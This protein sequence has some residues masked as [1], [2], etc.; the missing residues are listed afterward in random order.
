MTSHRTDPGPGHSSGSIR[1]IALVGHSGSGKTTLVEQLL[2][3][4]GTIGKPGRVEDGS[5]VCDFEAEEKSHG[6]SLYPA[7]ATVRHGGLVVHLIDTPGFPDFLGQTL[8]VLPASETVAVVV[9]ADKGI[10]TTTRRI[11]AVA[12]QRRLPRMVVVNRI[13]DHLGECEELLDRLRETF[14]SELLPIN[15]PTPDGSG[16]ADL[17]SSERG[18]SAF[19]SVAEAHQRL[20]DQVVEVD[21]ELMS[22]YLES[23]SVSPESLRAAFQKALR[24]GHL[25][26]VCFCSAKTGAGVEALLEIFEQLCPSPLEGNPRPFV[27]TTPEGESPYEPRPDPAGK[28]VGHVFKVTTDPFV[29][30]LCL[31]RIHQGTLKAGDSV[32]VNDG[33]KPVRIAHIHEVHG[34]EHPEIARAV[35]GDIVCITKVEDLH[36][37]DVIHGGTDLGGLRFRA[38]EMPR[39][40]YGLALA[41]KS[42]SDEA[43][44]ST[45]LAKL[46][47]EDPTFEVERVAATHQL[48]AR[49]MGELHMRVALERLRNRFKLDLD[50]E[51]PKVAYKE[52]VSS[53]AEGHHRHKKQTGGAG[54]FGEVSL[55]VEPIL[56]DD[57]LP[58]HR[59]FEFVDATVG[60]AVPRQFMPAIEKGIRQ[61]LAEGAIAGY[62][63]GG[64]RVEVFDGKHHPV[65]S[66]EVAFVTAGRRAFI[67]AVMKAKPQLLEPIVAV[68]VTAPSASMGDLTA[69]FSGRRGQVLD[70][71][72]LPGDLCMIRAEVPLSEMGT[73]SNTLKSMTAGQGSFVMDYSHDAAA[74]PNL[75]SAVVA[76]FTRRDEAED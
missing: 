74:P 44:V 8:S 60:G 76:S 9:G 51:P 62:P 36:F 11:L 75:Q 30:K 17:W 65:D 29:G 45:G 21:D 15:L 41:A 46:C 1:N 73:Y 6:H 66:K 31:V 72:M 37:N 14:G 38:I 53:R 50:T 57:G 39:P 47:E 32:L 43:K 34:R 27:L 33:T 20:V 59:R 26:P 40:M 22:Q 68:E 67:D 23:G 42:R 70:T 61:V 69:D 64:V 3:A 63:L 7:I 71:Q 54:Q 55:R 10:Q 35:P 24:T 5:T 4:A 18:E 12:G 52:S 2:A 13:D 28:L 19:S 58:D 25:V 48:V 49:A 16:V 56:G